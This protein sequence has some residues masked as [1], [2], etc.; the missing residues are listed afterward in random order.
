MIAHAM[1]DVLASSSPSSSAAAARLTVDLRRLPQ[2]LNRLED[3]ADAHE[4]EE[5]GVHEPR[6]DLHAHATKE[7]SKHAHNRVDESAKEA[8]ICVCPAPRLGL[9][10][11]HSGVKLLPLTS[12]RAYPYV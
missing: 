8:K 7:A 1:V 6:Q 11:R 2:A 9:H 12:Y 5:D 4:D 10:R 3:D